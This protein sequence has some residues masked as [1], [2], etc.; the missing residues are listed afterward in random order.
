M[1]LIR[2]VRIERFRGIQ[3]L[4]WAPGPGLNGLIGP[5]D[6]GKSTILDA[7]DLLLS[8]RRTA[9]FTD[10]DFHKLAVGDGILLEATIGDLPPQLLDL[11]RYGMFHRGWDVDLGVSDEPEDDNEIVIT[12][13]LTV[14]ADLDPTW[15]LYSE[16][17]EAEDCLRDLPFAERARLAPTR[18]GAFASHHLAWG[19]RSVLNRIADVRPAA[20]AALADAARQARATFGD[21]A[22]PEVADTIEMV[23]DVAARIGVHG[24]EGAAALLD[25]HG[26]SFGAGSIALHDGQGVPLKNLGQGSSRLLVA[27]LQAMAGNTSPFT[28]VDELEHGLEPFRIMRLLHELGAK[29]VVPPRQV[30]LTT[31][32]AVVIRELSAQQLWHVGR[33][34]AADRIV[35]RPLAR[36]AAAQGTLRACAEAYLAPSVL[37]CEGATE[38]G[39]IRGLDLY[40][41]GVGQ[42]PMGSCGVAV[43]DGSG[44]NMLQRALAFAR[45]GYRV[46]LWHDSDKE[47][48][49]GE[50]QQL[51]NA[52]V[53]RFFWDEPNSTEMQMFA[54]IHDDGILPLVELAREWNGADSVNDQIEAR[55][56]GFD[57]DDDTFGYTAEER[58][59]LGVA[60]TKGKWFKTVSYAET[61]GRDVVGPSLAA[62]GGRLV[63]T[64]DAIRAWILNEPAEAEEA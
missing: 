28:L 60:A 41:S 32:S 16:R 43:A 17:A 12:I 2:Q 36:D 31:H 46:A 18:L 53:A 3:A 25:A 10:A 35:L 5:G 55:N 59:A 9:G 11:D 21:A 49:A 30:F 39:L 4:E 26:V 61:A 33:D 51:E 22:A 52:G 40:W 14:G 19:A 45:A 64:I 27:G 42:R 7:I 20:G 57:V 37:V 48:N 24:A 56:P 1:P 44:S 8:A 34:P 54:S 63:E 15:T 58:A 13:R 50:L 23:R 6:S 29:E 47:L 38:V 62:S